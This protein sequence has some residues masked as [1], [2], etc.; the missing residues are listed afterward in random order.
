MEANEI[1]GQIVDSA[2]KMHMA[3]GPGLMERAYE[4]CLSYELRKRGLRV[5]PQV[6][7]PVRYDGKMIDLGLRL[8]LLVENEVI[9]ELKSV[10][11]IAPLHE[12]QLLSYLRMGNKRFGLLINFNVIYLKDGIKR[13]V[14]DYL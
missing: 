10:E 5:E 11:K 6:I 2:M 13:M 4:A 12:A 7:L 1:T 8:D 9:V 14:S 3:L